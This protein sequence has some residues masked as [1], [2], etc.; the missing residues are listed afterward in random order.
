[1]ACIVAEIDWRLNQ[2]YQGT[3]EHPRRI[4]RYLLEAYFCDGTSSE[5]LEHVSG[6]SYEEINRRINRALTYISGNR[7]R[8]RSYEDFVN[9]PKTPTV[10]RGVETRKLDKES[11]GVKRVMDWYK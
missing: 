11:N 8:T 6:L 1:V 9:H 4:D 10:K 7:R 2:V 3:K 5:L